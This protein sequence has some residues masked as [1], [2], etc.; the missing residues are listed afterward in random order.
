MTNRC[1]G[2]GESGVREGSEVIRKLNPGAEQLLAKPDLVHD[3]L[4]DAVFVQAFVW[5]TFFPK[6]LLHRQKEN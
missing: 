1:K 6:F 3:A 4:D 2:D 5:S